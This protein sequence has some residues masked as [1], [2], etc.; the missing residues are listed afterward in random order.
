MNTTAIYFDGKSSIPQDVQLTLD[1]TSGVLIFSTPSFKNRIVLSDVKTEKNG[2]FLLVLFENDPVQQIKI[3]D[4]KFQKE[5][6]NYLKINNNWYDKIVNL[7]IGTHILL[8]ILFLGFIGAIYFYGVPYIAEKAV[9]IIPEEYDNELSTLF[10]DEFIESEIVNQEKTKLLNDFS[11][12][13]QLNNTKPLKFTVIES[14]MVN[15]FALPDGNIIVFT[16]IID[17]IENSNELA[18]LIGHEAAHVNKRHSMKMLCRN[19]SGYLFISAVFN[20]IN[21]I[22]AIIGD[23]I[24]SL[25]S[26]SYSRTFE[27]EA[28]IEALEILQQNNIDPNG[29]LLLFDRL[30]SHSLVEIPEF[31]SSHPITK[32]RSSYIKQ[33]IKKESF[34][35]IENKKLNNLFKQL[36]SKKDS[37]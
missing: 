33:L 13:L 31:L 6:N 11:K 10:F 37:K 17:A 18:G 9:N 29:M 35:N 4:L 27:K 14:D 20:D 19:L 32:E 25:Q 23:N 26:M 24:H 5:L 34:K 15:A 36:K 12:E 16:G 1:K 8:S 22:T 7:N 2:K 3:E 21:G 30:E 28:D